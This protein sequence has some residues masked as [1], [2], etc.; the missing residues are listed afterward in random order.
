MNWNTTLFVTVLCDIVKEVI[1]A[2]PRATKAGMRVLESKIEQ[3]MYEHQ[4]MKSKIY[5]RTDNEKYIKIKKYILDALGGLDNI[6]FI[7]E[8]GRGI[9]FVFYNFDKVKYYHMKNFNCRVFISQ[10]RGSMILMPGSKGYIEIN[11]YLIP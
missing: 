6:A 11:K 7:Q 3:K 8:Y 10:K 4:I 1:K 5:S 9:M 2:V